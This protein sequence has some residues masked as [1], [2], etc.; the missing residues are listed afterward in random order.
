MLV[1]RGLRRTQRLLLQYGDT[2]AEPKLPATECSQSRHR[3]A[4]NRRV[5]SLTLRRGCTA[6]LPSRSQLLGLMMA[7]RSAPGSLS[8]SP[9]KMFRLASDPEYAATRCTRSRVCAGLV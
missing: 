3:L 1:P 8:A 2:G 7:M 9:G 4:Q 6:L 5:S